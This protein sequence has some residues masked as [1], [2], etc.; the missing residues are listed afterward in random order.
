MIRKIT[1]SL[2]AATLALGH[3]AAQTDDTTCS[4]MLPV[5]DGKTLLPGNAR[6][7]VGAD[8]D[9]FFDNREYKE[10]GGFSPSCTYFSATLVAYGG[11]QWDRRNSIAVG[12]DLTQDF[13]DGAKFLTD[14]KPVF[15]YSFRSQR[16]LASAGIIPNAQYLGRFSELFFDNSEWFYDNKIAGVLSHYRGRSG[17]VEFSIDWKGM[18][19]PKIRERFRILTDGE[20]RKGAFYGG[21]VFSMLHMANSA[22]PEIQE[23]VVENLTANPYVG[24]RGGRTW[25]FD[26]QAGFV[27]S[28]QRDRKADRSYRPAG[29]ELALSVERWGLQLSN[30]LYF[31]DN[32]MPMYAQYGS[33]VYSGSP[34][35][36]TTEKFYNRTAIEFNRRFFNDTVGIRAGIVLHYDGV[37]MGTQQLLQVDVRLQKSFEKRRQTH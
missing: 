10:M 16:V 3:A 12:I 4:D 34:L 29:G 11:L 19:S 14:V 6:F 20:W 8:F 9:T 25:H 28:I 37:G 2:L 7:F 24:F 33:L 13:G 21:Y 15:F 26:V 36:A 30:R 22:D 32:Q 18:Q 17:F 27:Q 5:R 1:L 23:G 31:G 35:Y